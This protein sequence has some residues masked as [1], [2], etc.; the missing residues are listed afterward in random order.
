MKWIHK[1]FIFFISN[2]CEKKTCEDAN[3]FKTVVIKSSLNLIVAIANNF[4]CIFTGIK[5]FLS[6]KEYEKKRIFFKFNRQVGYL[7]FASDQ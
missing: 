6:K 4:I 3:V 2:V 1:N 7:E 5:N